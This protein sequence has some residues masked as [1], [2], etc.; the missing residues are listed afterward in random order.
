MKRKQIHPGT[1]GVNWTQVKSNQ[2]EHKRHESANMTIVAA[3][4]NMGV[5]IVPAKF[6][7]TGARCC[8]DEARKKKKNTVRHI[9]KKKGKKRSN[10]GTAQS[11][12]SFLTLI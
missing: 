10:N 2:M 4:L 3:L 1:D 7:R 12:E 6:C 8:T 9:L 5:Q 11:T